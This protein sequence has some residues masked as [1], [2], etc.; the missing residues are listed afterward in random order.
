MDIYEEPTQ[1]QWRGTIARIA[2]QIDDL[3]VRIEIESR[4]LYTKLSAEIAALQADLRNLQTEVSATGPDMYARQIAARIEELRARGDAAYDLLQ[5]GFPPQLD[6]A[7]VE[8]R[9]LEA[10]ASSVTGDTKLKL[11]TRIDDLKAARMAAHAV[12][13]ANDRTR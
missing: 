11:L 2:A 4:T 8:I 12:N 1:A 9:R 3:K 13:H 5:T 6:P 7:D 10:L